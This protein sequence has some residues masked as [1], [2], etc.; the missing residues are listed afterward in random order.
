MS[1]KSAPPPWKFCT[2][3]EILLWIRPC[4]G[5]SPLEPHRGAAPGPRWGLAPPRWL[6]RLIIISWSDNSSLVMSFISC[7]MA[8]KMSSWPSNDW[9]LMPEF[10][11]RNK[12]RSQI[13]RSWLKGLWFV[14]PT[15]EVF[16]KSWLLLRCEAWH[17]PTSKTTDLWIKSY[18]SER[19][20]LVYHQQ[21]R[22]VAVTS[23]ILASL[24]L[25]CALWRAQKVWSSC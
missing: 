14:S 15:F 17:C 18:L 13:F 6:R 11:L 2:P 25:A 8:C 3:S 7:W 21:Y 23:L 19:L 1:W 24:I 12:N 22:P 16:R 4:S 20:P 10:S 5:A 9:F